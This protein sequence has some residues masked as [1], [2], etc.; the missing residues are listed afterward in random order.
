MIY[1]KLST[2]LIPLL[3]IIFYL[4]YWS[5]NKSKFSTN[6][7]LKRCGVIC[8]S[9]SEIIIPEK[10]YKSD[11][12]MFLCN[13]KLFKND[14]NLTQ[15]KSCHRDSQINKISRKFITTNKLKKFLIGKIFERSVLLFPVIFGLMIIIDSNISL[16]GSNQLISV[17][18]QVVLIIYWLLNIYKV[19]FITENRYKTSHFCEVFSGPTRRVSNYP[20]LYF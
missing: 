10:D 19:W 2:A 13:N 18:N 7:Y 17:L 16:F 15:C 9:C 12:L 4:V 14:N 1:F 5:K 6:L 20:P 11:V 3:L 8:F